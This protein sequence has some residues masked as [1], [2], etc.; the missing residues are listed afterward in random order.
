MNATDV[1]AL[2]AS[3]VEN[4]QALFTYA[5]SLTRNREAAE[6]AIQAVFERL[7]RGAKLPKQ[8]RPYLFRAVRNAAY[9]ALRRA[10]VRDDAI[11]ELAGAAQADGEASPGVNPDED[12]APLLQRLSGDERETIILKIYSGLTFQQI[13]DVRGVPLPTA[14]SWYR[15]GLERMKILLHEAS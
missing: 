7:L 3:Y 14:A 2:H 11:F 15:R 6:D 1:A 13:A 12:L 10:R 5:L 8:L 4:R 9:D